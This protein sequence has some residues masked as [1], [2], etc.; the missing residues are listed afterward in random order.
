[1]AYR[2]R[3]KDEAI[4]QKR[5]RFGTFLILQ[6]TDMEEIQQMEAMGS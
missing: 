6:D 5:I 4:G 3:E 2:T 1:V